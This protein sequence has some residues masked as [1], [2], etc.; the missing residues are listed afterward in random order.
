MSEHEFNNMKYPLPNNELFVSE[1]PKEISEYNILTKSEVDRLEV[2]KI[3]KE[4]KWDAYRI[5]SD[6]Y[7]LVQYCF[8]IETSLQMNILR[9]D[10]RYVDD[11]GQKVIGNYYIPHFF[12]RHSKTNLENSREV[13]CDKDI[14]VNYG[15]EEI[16]DLI[17]NIPAKQSNIHI[18]FLTNEQ[19]KTVAIASR[20]ER[21]RNYLNNLGY[22]VL[23][24]FAYNADDEIC[25]EDFSFGSFSWDDPIYDTITV[26]IDICSNERRIK[27]NTINWLTLGGPESEMP[28]GGRLIYISYIF[29]SDYYD[30]ISN[31]QIHSLPEWMHID[32]P[33][34]YLFPM[35]VYYP[36]SSNV[37]VD[38]RDWNI[39]RLIWNFKGE[40]GK[41]T[42]EEHEKALSEVIECVTRSI[43]CTFG[44]D[45]NK[46]ITLCCVPSSTH[47]SYV[48]RFKQFSQ[49]VSENLNM[50]NGFDLIN[51]IEDSTPKH[52][53]G[54]GKPKY[55][56]KENNLEGRLIILFDDIYTTGR[57]M[58]TLCSKL[59]KHGAR[60]I[61]GLTIG[62]TKT[63][64]DYET[65]E[66]G[67]G[68]YKG[69]YDLYSDNIW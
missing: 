25:D 49:S 29:E 50:I 33:P 67:G 59:A 2:E 61:G 51:Y 53:G 10:Y 27:D 40:P 41:I 22:N 4:S 31:E 9:C 11:K 18:G 35:W 23:F 37:I 32:R 47:D 69:I 48:V 58:A 38:E 62:I 5:L 3:E 68:Y 43:G 64:K 54:S 17:A 16:Y 21:I 60:V 44:F 57:C 6:Q 8:E 42:K 24:N 65:K 56:I 52:L 20:F 12:L 26:F 39:R 7:H 34:Y 66:L 19:N 63:D 15:I 13:L 28:Y 46:E 45:T 36:V 55:E 1:M 14:D 30:H